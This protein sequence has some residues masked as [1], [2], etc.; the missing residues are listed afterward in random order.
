MV[1]FSMTS[2]SSAFCTVLNLQC[3]GS[4]IVML[5]DANCRHRRYIYLYLHA[6][7]SDCNAEAVSLVYRAEQGQTKAPP[8][9]PFAQLS[10]CSAALTNGRREHP[11]VQYVALV[12]MLDY[13]TTPGNKLELLAALQ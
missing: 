12:Y 10:P 13:S 11:A 7:G 6:Q 3:K 5:A 4:A 1:P 9:L 8:H 2:T